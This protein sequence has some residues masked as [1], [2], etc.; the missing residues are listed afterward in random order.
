MKFCSYTNFEVVFA[1]VMIDFPFLCFNLKFFGLLELEFHAN[2]MK[3]AP[4]VNV[5]LLRF[6][7]QSRPA[8]LETRL[9]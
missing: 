7:L 5:F 8:S 9:R 1:I 6:R 3:S 4:F 2:K